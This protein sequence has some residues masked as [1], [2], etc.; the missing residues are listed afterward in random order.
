MAIVKMNKFTLL[1]FESKKD[2]L[3]EKLQSFSQ[4]E[5]INL[6]DENLLENNEVFQDL[7]KDLIIPMEVDSDGEKLVDNVKV[8]SMTEIGLEDYFP[9]NLNQLEGSPYPIYAHFIKYNHNDHNHYIDQ[10][11]RSSFGDTGKWIISDTGAI[12][13]KGDYYECG[14][15]PIIRLGLKEY[16]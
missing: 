14:A 12:V 1:A 9:I 16:K 6:Q 11:T 15:A 2:E 7:A 8:I 5:F 4:A 10:F 3:L 13:Y